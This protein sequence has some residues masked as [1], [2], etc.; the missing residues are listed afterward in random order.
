MKRYQNLCL[1]ICFAIFLSVGLSSP[2][3]TAQSVPSASA[4]PES[5]APS[6]EGWHLDVTP[7]LWFAGGH[8]TAGVQGHDASIHA[9]ASDVLSNFNIGFMGVVEPRYNRVLSQPISCGSS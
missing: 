6:D 2:A 9:D 1:T 8:G 3:S 7:Y 4:K 5:P